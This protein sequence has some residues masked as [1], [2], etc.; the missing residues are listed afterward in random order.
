[1]KTN[2]SYPEAKLGVW[3]DILSGKLELIQV[4]DVE[5]FALIQNV[6]SSDHDRDPAKQIDEDEEENLGKF[7]LRMNYKL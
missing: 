3:P 1:M 2:R 6:Q 5:K 4:L 7:E